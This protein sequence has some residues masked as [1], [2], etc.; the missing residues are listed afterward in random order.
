MVERHV[1]ILAIVAVIAAWI[2]FP[3]SAH[4]QYALGSVSSIVNETC[5]A[6]LGGHASDWVTQTNGGTDIQ[7]ACYHATI[8]CPQ[9]TDLGVTYGVATPTTPSNGTIVFVPAK[10]GINTLP[11]NYIGEIPWDLYHDSYQTIQFAF[12]SQ[13][14]LTGTSTASLKV[15]ACRVATILNF[16]YTSFYLAN[17]NNSPTAGMCAH[18][19]SGG[20]G[21]LGF[22]LTYY[23]VGSFLDKAGFVSGPEYG[24]LVNGCTT[25]IHP[26][27]NICPAPNGVYAMGCNTVAG[28][29][30]DRP[31]YQQGSAQNLSVELDDNPPCYDK[32]YTYTSSSKHTLAATSVVDNGTDGTFTYPQTA[33]SAYLCD[34]DSIWKNP[35]E[36]QGWAYYSQFT[37]SSVPETCNYTGSNSST[38][39]SCLMVNRVYGCTTVEEAAT[40]FMCVGANCPVC[41]G[42]PPSCTCGGVACDQHKTPTYAMRVNAEADYEDPVN[43]CI[44]RHGA[45]QSRQTQKP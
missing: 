16:L 26:P 15:A 5:P 43:G 9:T 29:W 44:S 2:T 37:N 42:T 28:S 22:A 6:A 36:A 10:F 45:P 3:P 7:T 24:N 38:P 4:A 20:A 31:N 23:G 32:T 14:Q 19:Q 17:T 33:V 34:D 25:P 13:W 27:T 18:S 40:G 30:Q 1:Q 35:S 11:G 39:N 12:D 21:G 8:I 41:T